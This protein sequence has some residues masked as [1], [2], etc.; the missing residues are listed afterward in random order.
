MMQTM[1]VASDQA[2]LG[3]D[4]KLMLIVVTGPFIFIS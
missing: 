1:K 3:G 2:N 4:N